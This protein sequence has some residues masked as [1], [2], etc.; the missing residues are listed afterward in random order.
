MDRTLTPLI[1]AISSLK[2]GTGIV[3]HQASRHA[4]YSPSLTV[5]LCECIKVVVST[6]L[7]TKAM[8]E[9]RLSDRFES[10][11]YTPLGAHPNESTDSLLDKDTSP[12]AAEVVEPQRRTLVHQ[13][14]G[15]IFVLQGFRLMAPA[16]IYVVQN[17]LYLFAASELDPAFFQALWQFRILVSAVLSRFVLKRTIV[18]KQWGC[19]VG[20]FA[21][22]ML[23]KYATGGHDH[24]PADAAAHAS[25]PN[26]LA[27]MALCF[28]ALLSS[29]AGVILEFIYQDRTCHL[30]ASN[31][32]LSVFSILPA[33]AVTIFQPQDL[34]P[35][36]R[37]LHRSPWPLA[38]VF[39]Q[40][41]NGIMIALLLKKAG[42]IVND[43]TSAVSIILTFALNSMLF[44]EDSKIGGV[45][46]V[47]LVVMGSAVILVASVCYQRFSV[48]TPKP[49]AQEA[50][51]SLPLSSPRHNSLLSSSSDS[52]LQGSYTD[53]SDPKYDAELLPMVERDQIVWQQPEAD[54]HLES[55]ASHPLL[56]PAL[57]EKNLSA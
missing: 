39:C 44:P 55:D 41:F 40:S 53:L 45:G 31:V 54:A 56:S 34:T 23:V 57:P 35:V 29:V 24:A 37:D 32:H 6:C 2:S 51:V 49:A 28:A 46:D 22:V 25:Q 42:V 27:I 15:Q 14:L 47:L 7:L 4:A 21:G 16:L 12:E 33:A 30:W 52:T 9:K 10:T 3:F 8:Y 1:A 11:Q 48:S 43:L 38:V 19:L 36:L 20:I 18:A 13:V 26:A 5:L 50:A 17:N